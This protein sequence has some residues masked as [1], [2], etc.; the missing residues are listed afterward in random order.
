[1]ERLKGI[2]ASNISALRTASSM[3]QLELAERLNYSDKSVSKWERAEA[4]P[5]IA[6]LKSIADMFGVSV[7]YLITEHENVSLGENSAPSEVSH[8][9]IVGIAVIGIFTVALLIF[10]IL[11]IL[12]RVEWLIFVAA[13]PVALITVLI[14]HSVWCHGKHNFYIISALVLSIFA[15]VYLFLL[16]KNLWQI[17]LLAIPTL[18]I[19]YFCFRIKRRKKI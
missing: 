9:N 3:T 4:V 18:L 10:I 2:I 8:R 13:L 1:M 19:V 15:A 7:D 17:F 11:W 14:L 5:D 16:P 6:V 12:G